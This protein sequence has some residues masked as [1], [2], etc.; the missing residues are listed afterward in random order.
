MLRN[1]TYLHFPTASPTN[2]TH[3]EL[4]PYEDCGLPIGSNLNLIQ[5]TSL[6]TALYLPS[7]TYPWKYSRPKMAFQQFLR[8]K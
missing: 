2:Q 7:G 6:S 1:P 4:L 5:G 3:K 8:P